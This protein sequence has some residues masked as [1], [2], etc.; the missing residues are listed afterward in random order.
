MNVSAYIFVETS[1]GKAKE[2]C[3][4]ISKIEGIKACNVVTGPFDLIVLVEAP[5]VNA[6]GSLVVS[7]I[8]FIKGVK[9][10]QTNIIVE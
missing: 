10:T 8:Q 9:R 4:E 7:K 3:E 5:N 2:V 1:H 6:I